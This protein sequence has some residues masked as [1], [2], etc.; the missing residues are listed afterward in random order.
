MADPLL[1][2]LLAAVW[3]IPTFVCLSDLQRREGVRRVL[4]WKWTAVLCVP[5]AGAALYWTRGRRGLDH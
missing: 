2:A 4:V 5:V 3:W 1:V